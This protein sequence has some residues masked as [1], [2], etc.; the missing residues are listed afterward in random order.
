M[1]AGLNLNL[2]MKK[3]K[4]IEIF[5]G[6]LILLFVY[7]AFSKLFDHQ[8]FSEDMHNQPFPRWMASFF[9]WSVP[10]IELLIS[11]C[12]L[13]ERTRKT[14]FYA[15]LF[16]LTLFTLYIAAILLHF[17]PRTPCSCGGVI[18]KLS[19]QQHL[20]FNLFFMTLSVAGIRL[21]SRLPDKSSHQLNLML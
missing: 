17:F 5:A 15:S 13:F 12:L 21:Q 19:W 16:L 8:K 2:F 9:V 6:L 10:S 1:P 4:I 18:R 14:G 11:G 20:W 3:S 7:A